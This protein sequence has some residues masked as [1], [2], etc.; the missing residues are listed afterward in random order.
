MANCSN[1]VYYK[2]APL[3]KK[4]CVNRSVSETKFQLLHNSSLSCPFYSPIL[5]YVAARGG[6]DKWEQV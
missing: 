6:H 1:C 4:D 2:N 5:R 3:F